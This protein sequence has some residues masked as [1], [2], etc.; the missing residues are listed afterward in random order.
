MHTRHFL[1]LLCPGLCSVLGLGPSGPLVGVVT[2]WNGGAEQSRLRTR[3]DHSMGTK[4][5]RRAGRYL[6]LR[7]AVAPGRPGGAGPEGRAATVDVV[8]QFLVLDWMSKRHASGL[9]R[10]RWRL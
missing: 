3:V 5:A 1:E 8:R 2:Y 9:Q 10:R 7:D 6:R 4:D